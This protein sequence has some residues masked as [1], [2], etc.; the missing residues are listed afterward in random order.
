M[1]GKKPNTKLYRVTQPNTW[2]FKINEQ[3]EL[4]DLQASKLTNKIELIPEVA[5]AR[6]TTS[7]KTETKTETEAWGAPE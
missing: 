6:K 3:V 5:K 7:A 4:T 1:A 2:D